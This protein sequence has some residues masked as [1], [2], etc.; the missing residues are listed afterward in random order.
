MGGEE[1]EEGGVRWRI[2]GER[3]SPQSSGLTYGTRNTYISYIRVSPH[4]IP[5][6][7]NINP[8]LLQHKHPHRNPQPRPIT[9]LPYQHNNDPHQPSLHTHRY[10]RHPLLVQHTL[11]LRH[12]LLR[13]GG[14]GGGRVVTE[15]G[16]G[17]EG[18]E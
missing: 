14:G 11:D 5:Q 1:G 12:L 17:L 8:P 7:K 6:K 16:E 13:F 15:V 3:S 4:P 18:F 2:F 9:P 10:P